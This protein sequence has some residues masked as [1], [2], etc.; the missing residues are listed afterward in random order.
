MIHVFRL[1]A[2]L[3]KIR[4]LLNERPL[5]VLLFPRLSDLFTFKQKLLYRSYILSKSFFRHYHSFSLVQKHRKSVQ[6]RNVIQSQTRACSYYVDG[7]NPLPVV[8]GD[9]LFWLVIFFGLVISLK[10]QIELSG[11]H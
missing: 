6:F 5:T 3:V 1:L 7:V 11:I 10:I 9:F 4:I 8:D 2:T